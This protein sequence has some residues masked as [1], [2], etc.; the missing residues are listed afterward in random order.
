MK[1]MKLL[2]IKLFF[3]IPVYA[4][5]LE[6]FKSF[7]QNVSEL[8]NNEPCINFIENHCFRA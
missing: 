2:D 4:Q 7:F 8:I 6:R 3:G 1:F 5:P